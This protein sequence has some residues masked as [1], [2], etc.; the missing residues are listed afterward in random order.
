MRLREYSS[1][2]NSANS[3]LLLRL[4]LEDNPEDGKLFSAGGPG[5]KMEVG[6][7]AYGLQPFLKRVSCKEFLLRLMEEVMFI[8][9]FASKDVAHCGYHVC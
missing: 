9:H 6:V 2:C 5:K 4:Y 8:P 7:T 1:P 3:G